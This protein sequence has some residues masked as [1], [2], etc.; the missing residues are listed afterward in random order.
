[1]KI[2]QRKE[3]KNK[4]S[5]TVNVRW[6]SISNEET[7]NPSG[8][9]VSVKAQEHVFAVI[10]ATGLCTCREKGGRKVKVSRET[11]TMFPRLPR[12]SRLPDQHR[13]SVR[14]LSVNRSERMLFQ[15]VPIY[16]NCRSRE[17]IHKRKWILTE[18]V[19]LLC[20]SL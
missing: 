7:R 12:L 18:I 3:K 13:D 16:Q 4:V 11:L 20:C 6:K 8:F 17:I 9:T 15:I 10:F 2:K 14:I 1:M 5:N 19:S